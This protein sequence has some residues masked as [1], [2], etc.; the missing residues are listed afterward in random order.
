MKLRS[1]DLF[2][3]IGGFALA[4][5]QI[6][7]PV[8][9]CDSD[10]RAVELLRAQM[11]R[12]RLAKAPVFPDVK[13]LRAAQLRTPVDLI[14]AGFPCPDVSVSGPKLGVRGGER[15]SLIKHVFRLARELHP[16]YIFLENVPNIANDRIGFK[17]IQ[18]QLEKLGYDFAYDFV[19]AASLGAAHMRDRWFLLA[20]RRRPRARQVHPRCPPKLI[21]LLKLKKRRV[22]VD[23]SEAN[24]QALRQFGNAVVP[25]AACAAFKRLLALLD[26]PPAD[27]EAGGGPN[28]GTGHGGIQ[29]E[30]LYVSFRRAPRQTC[31]QGPFRVFPPKPLSTSNHT[32]TPLTSP[33]NVPCLPT[34]RV[35]S[36]S[37]TMTARTKGDL[38]PVALASNLSE[39]RRVP[40]A[41]ARGALSPSFVANLM[42]YP[43]DWHGR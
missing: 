10:P 41:R 11:T 36:S 26:R 6:A 33:F 2:S 1:L 5:Q 15:T 14:T 27:A 40:S 34:P 24:P 19:S 42:G 35:S 16:S 25:A 4:L 31:S 17:W 32:L 21:Q 43:I 8:A 28:A 13:K 30:G 22:S 39:V 20:R 3:G 18:R 7:T 12:G 37:G 23:F 38:A 9:Y 29:T